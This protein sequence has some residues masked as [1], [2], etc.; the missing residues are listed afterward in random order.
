MRMSLI[1][2]RINFKDYLTKNKS[3][4]SCDEKKNGKNNLTA[5]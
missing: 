2:C 1:L 4:K 5:D 3:F